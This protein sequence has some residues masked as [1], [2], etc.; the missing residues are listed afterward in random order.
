MEH[1]KPTP[2]GIINDRSTA[3]AAFPAGSG[4][5]QPAGKLG[6]RIGIAT[7]VGVAPPPGPLVCEAVHPPRTR[8]SGTYWEGT[9]D[10]RYA[11]G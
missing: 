7:D 9:A 6:T 10:A 2:F 11:W 3:D 1:E 8:G 4:A 5:W